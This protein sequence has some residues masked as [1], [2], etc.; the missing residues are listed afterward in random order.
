MC[1][2]Y[3]RRQATRWQY[4]IFWAYIQKLSAIASG[5]TLIG[6]AGR[7]PNKKK[8]TKGRRRD[9]SLWSATS[10]R[11]QPQGLLTSEAL[12]VH[13]IIE[14]QPV[15]N[16]Y[17]R[18]RLSLVDNVLRLHCRQNKDQ[19]L[20]LGVIYENLRKIANSNSLHI[21]TVKQGCDIWFSSCV[22]A[23]KFE[24]HDWNISWR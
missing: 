2:N 9:W 10:T 11:P 4:Y 21:L 17:R 8:S 18:N 15:D 20:P 19:L 6:S 23:T 12:V 22:I 13:P 24:Y 5:A 1:Q 16:W 3:C 7:A 14:N